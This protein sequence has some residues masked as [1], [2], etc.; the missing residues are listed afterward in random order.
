[1]NE[2][3]L[4]DFEDLLQD[5]K[6]DS[7]LLHSVLGRLPRSCYTSIEIVHFFDKVWTLRREFVCIEFLPL[8]IV[9]DLYIPN[10]LTMQ[11]NDFQL[12]SMWD[13]K[14]TRRKLQFHV[15]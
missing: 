11:M 13:F 12:M 15:D 4:Q 14:I 1:M 2:A 10:Y 5:K 9:T 3:A 7:R 8:L 6:E